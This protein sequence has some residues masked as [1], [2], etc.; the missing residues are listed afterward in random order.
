MQQEHRLVLALALSALVLFLARMYMAP[1]KPSAPIPIQKTEISKEQGS[2]EK[3]KSPLQEKS[4]PESA[5]NEIV[6]SSAT[7]APER[8]IIIE[9]PKY[10][11]VL[12]SLGARIES[13][14]HREKSGNEME[15][16]LQ[17]KPKELKELYGPLA[18]LSD[19][20]SLQDKLNNVSYEIFSGKEKVSND[21]LKTPADLLCV[22]QEGSLKISKKLEFKESSYLVETNTEVE[23]QG[24]KLEGLKMRIGPA[25]GAV[26]SLLNKETWDTQRLAYFSNGSLT[27]LEYKSI[28][29]TQTLEG[30]IPWAGIQ[31]QYFAVLA[32]SPEAKSLQG[33]KIQSWKYKGKDQKNQDK[34]FI[35]AGIDVPLFYGETQKIYFGPKEDQLLKSIHPSLDKVIDY[36][37]FRILVEPL[38][39]ALRW[40]H[41]IAPNYGL[42]IIIMT[43]LITLVLF[44]LRF[45]QILSMKKMQKIQPQM[46]SIQEKYKKS[47]SSAEERQ[48]MNVEMM[49]LYKEH[50]V[51]PVGGCLPLLIQFPFLIAVN[52]LVGNHFNLR[53]APFFLWIQNLAAPDPY[54]VT[55]IVMGITMFLSMKLTTPPTTGDPMQNK[56]MAWMMPGMMTFFFLGLSA[57][58][59][60]YFLF[61]NI[62]SIGLQKLAERYIPA[63]K[64]G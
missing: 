55:P 54:Y 64:N 48:K 47:K 57:G 51:N 39:Y 7:Q 23:Y 46:K 34:E 8:T 31:D 44:P 10:R 5:K 32:L 11:V 60:L 29:S 28:E 22:Y 36:G 13:W 14:K 27:K 16:V 62:F 45:K 49:A 15:L 26:D 38:L 12:K 41:S 37:W 43:F 58:L 19:D 30:S 3:E 9:D 24:K 6:P 21:S 63:L 18:I 61:S 52:N 40:L 25:M 1:E 53:G 17:E 35:I 4:S 50:G 42:A 59:N 56:M 20:K 33:G 2:V